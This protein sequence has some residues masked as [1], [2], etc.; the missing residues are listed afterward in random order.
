MTAAEREK[1]LAVD[2]CG[3]RVVARLRSIG[4]RR[5]ADLD[6][7]DP[8]ELMHRVNVKAGRPIW[9]APMAIIALENLVEA[10]RRDS[11]GAPTGRA[12]GDELCAA[13]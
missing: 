5:L 8:W 6:G 13:G 11:T 12:C 2:M 4:I 3:P 1:M 7:S 10:A 9:H